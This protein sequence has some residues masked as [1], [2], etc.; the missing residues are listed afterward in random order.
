MDAEVSVVDQGVRPGRGHQVV[1]PDD[2]ARGLDE[3]KKQIERPAPERD[4][5]LPAK[6]E[7][8]VRHEREGAQ[9][10]ELHGECTWRPT[11]VGSSDAAIAF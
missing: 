8:L 10:P 9:L 7:P 4:A 2:L 11:L 6:Q 5:L 1:L 3:T